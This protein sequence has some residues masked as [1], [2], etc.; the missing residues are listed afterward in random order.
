MGPRKKLSPTEN[1]AIWQYNTSLDYLRGIG[2]TKD[3]ARA[4]RW[5]RAAARSGYPDAVLAMG[6]FYH[7]GIGVERNL[8]RARLWYRRAARAKNASA[9]FSLGQLAYDDDEFVE[10]AVWFRQAVRRRHPR[11]GYYLARLYL[12]GRGVRRNVAT[13][14]KLLSDAVRYELPE[15]KRLL[16]SKRFQRARDF[17]GG[18]P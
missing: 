6:W 4:F 18:R 9:Q 13:A 3:V 8:R 10:A 12:D 2:A 14:S 16:H 15:A 5:N 7:N 17:V 11:A 1:R